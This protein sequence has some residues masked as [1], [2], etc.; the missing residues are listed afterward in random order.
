MAGITKAAVIGAGVMGAGIAAHMANAGMTVVL[1]DVVPDGAEDRS[2]IAKSAVERLAKARP[3]ALAAPECAALITP[4]NL[5]D[6][7]DLLA[8]AEWV[9]EAVVENLAIK[10]DVLERVARAAPNAAVCSNTSTLPLAALTEGLPSFIASRLLITHFFNPPRQMKLVELVSGPATSPVTTAKIAAALDRQLGKSVIRCADTPGFV[11]NRLGTY[12]MCLA[13]AEAAAQGIG[14]AEADAVLGAPFGVPP[15]GVFGLLDLIGLDTI[16]KGCASL[17]GALAT[18]D[19]FQAVGGP[20]AALFRIMVERRLLGRKAKAGFFKSITGPDGVTQRRELDMAALDYRDAVSVAPKTLPG[21]GRDPGAMIAG[22]DRLSAYAW[23]V[24]SGT[25]AYA[26]AMVPEAAGSPADVDAAMTLGYGWRQG[27]FQLMDAIGLDVLRDRYRTS[28]LAVPALLERAGESFYRGGAEGRTVL[29]ADGRRVAVPRPEDII[30]AEDLRRAGP[31]VIGNRSASLWDMGDGIALFEVHCKM[32]TL[33][34]EVAALLAQSLEVVRTRF[35]GL[36]IGNDAANFSAGANLATTVEWIKAGDFA[37]LETTLAAGQQA[38]LALKYAPFP[39]VGAL[40]GVALGG[41]CEILLHCDAVQS[42][43]ECSIG[44]VERN[45][46]IL[47]GWGGVAQMLAR[48]S[49]ATGNGLDGAVAAFATIGRAATASS[50]H[51]AGNYLFLRP[52]DPV[53]MNRD[54]LLADAKALAVSLAPG[55]RPPAAARFDLGGEALRA[56]LA[57]ALRTLAADKDT[58]P[59]DM[60]IA[61]ILAWVLGGGDGGPGVRDEADVHALER[62]AILRLVRDDRTVAR[63]EHMLATGKPLRN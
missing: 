36:V 21:G 9:V 62:A 60:T 25:F 7:L 34:G 13:V 24:L 20:A 46:G 42:H 30:L 43:L 2:V 28:G 48:Y 58:S 53:T 12:W 39:V 27:P 15:T 5:A 54:R 3:A 31:P 8:D 61:E 47:P 10:R 1:L 38:M 23:S 41:G 44:L 49:E 32:N 57:A 18:G 45:V 11:A 37:A 4:G 40:A 16:E 14:P 19:A 50:A 55:Y 6:H 51:L 59:Y 22:S 33:D 56:A 26:C 63:M 52:N 35:R 29:G 17:R